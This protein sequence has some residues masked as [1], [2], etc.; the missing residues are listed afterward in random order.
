MV[1]LAPCP[2]NAK[3]TAGLDAWRERR[4]SD[5]APRA[6]DMLRDEPPIVL[7]HSFVAEPVAGQADYVLLSVGGEVMTVLGLS[8]RSDRL[9][10]I[11]ARR[12]AVRLRR[13][14]ELVASYGEPIAVRFT[15]KG[16]DFEI[17]AAPILSEGGAPALF[18]T[19]GVAGSLAMKRPL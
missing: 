16:A 5:L 17:L 8:G 14:F 4:G 6:M 3:V 19:I 15:D 1:D 7:D 2:Q 13:L 18:C 11:T 12:L 9:S 10:Q